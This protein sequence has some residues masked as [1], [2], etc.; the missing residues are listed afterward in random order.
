MR[1]AAADGASPVRK[2]EKE[3]DMKKALSMVLCAAMAFS[4][5]ACGKSGNGGGSTGKPDD[6]AG[7][8][9]AAG[10]AAGSE[11]APAETAPATTE[12]AAQV[13][14]VPSKEDT[15]STYDVRNEIVEGEVFDYYINAD[16]TALITWYSGEE[17]SVVIPAE[18]DGHTVTG[19][20]HRS[21]SFSYV[22]AKEITIP[23]G[24]TAIYGNPFNECKT[25]ETIKVEEGSKA[26]TVTDNCLIRLSDMTLVSFPS[27]GGSDSLT[28]PD[29]V[30]A[31]GDWAFADVYSCSEIIMP[32]SVT[33]VEDHAFIRTGVS[34][35]SFSPNLE[36]IGDY[37]FAY[38]YIP[39]LDLP[40]SLRS[41]GEMAFSGCSIQELKLPENLESLGADAFNNCQSLTKAELP[42]SLREMT[43]YPFSVCPNLMELNLAADNKTFSISGPCLVDNEK[44]ALI[45]CIGAGENGEVTVP[46][47][48]EQI[49]KKA[50][51]GLKSLTAVK[52]PESL[53]EI[54]DYAFED[55]K[56]LVSVNLPEGLKE[57]G[58]EAFSNCESLTGI[59]I[60]DGVEKVG[61]SAFYWCS[62]LTEA[63]IPG[64]LKTIE[65]NSFM[66]C[67]GLTKVTIGEG[68]E[69]IEDGAFNSCE[70]VT[71]VTLPETLTSIGKEAFRYCSA[72]KTI[73]LPAGLTEIDSSAFEHCS[74]MD[75]AVKGGSYA[76]DFCK[77][78]SIK[79]HTN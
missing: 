76:E 59:Q 52:L 55:C 32:E 36:K 48:V 47:G 30:K 3:K 42:A 58:I 17:E 29:G 22:V 20:N 46:D 2:E 40:G 62:G 75:A 50:F 33:E 77:Q 70:A 78:K 18:L 53:K 57:I 15:Y 69:T 71:E 28:I 43:G 6:T 65:R 74:E 72:L 10:T 35:V 54:G 23:A 13:P 51:S 63:V 25:L 11:N 5:A 14:F 60:P 39:T 7:K 21:F 1:C 38:A 9:T 44:H 4:L 31:I 56:G 34:S 49:Y 66:Y 73:N 45:G 8:A 12:V 41:I 64:S 37:G 27:K 67:R 26:F 16:N 24:V 79:Y 61:S 19:I 68:V